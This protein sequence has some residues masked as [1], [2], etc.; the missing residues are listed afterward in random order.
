MSPFLLMA[1]TGGIAAGSI[2]AGADVSNPNRSINRSLVAGA[3]D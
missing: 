1:L 3:G 2:T